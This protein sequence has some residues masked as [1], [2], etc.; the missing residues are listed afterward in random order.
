MN[1][2]PLTLRGL[3]PA[4][5]VPFDR[6]LEIIESEFA[7]HMAAMGRIEG[8]SGVALNGHQGEVAAPTPR[9]RMR[10][11]EIAREQLPKD[12]HVIS[13][14]ISPSIADMAQQMKDARS[15]GADACLV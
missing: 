7:A 2:K 8:L 11:V 5:S 12:K 10:V 14:V 15:A 4:P 3:Y 1:K 6:D 9:E 13:G